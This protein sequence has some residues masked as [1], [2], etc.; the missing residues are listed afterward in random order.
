MDAPEPVALEVL[1][2]PFRITGRGDLYVV[3]APE[4]L[5]TSAEI[6]GRD[7]MVDGQRRRALGVESFRHEFYPSRW[8]GLGILFAPAT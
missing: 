6:V 3:Q 7:F 5:T 2:G 8:Y 4:S 1:D